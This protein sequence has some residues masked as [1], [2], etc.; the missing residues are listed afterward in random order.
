M[1]MTHM[2]WRSRA[3]ATI[4]MAVLLA[5]CG[6]AAHKAG[7][8]GQSQ[9]QNRDMYLGHRTGDTLDPDMVTAVSTAHSS[10]PISMKFR[11]SARPVVGTPLRVV[12]VLIPAADVGI[13]HIHASFQPGEGLQMQAERNFDVN[14]PSAGAGIE[15][16]LSV[17]PQQPG[18]LSLN[19]TIMVDMDSGSLARSYSIPLIASDNPSQPRSP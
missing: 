14:D 1:K 6:Q 17:V 2:V 12:V 8:A 5:A 11:V 7:A 13:S 15:Q 18:V 16:E 19:A 9:Q 10:T 3:L 4:A